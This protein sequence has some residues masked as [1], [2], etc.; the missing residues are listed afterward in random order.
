[1]VTTPPGARVSAGPAKRGTSPTELVVGAPLHGDVGVIA[2]LPGYESA[3]VT[4]KA[5][6]FSPTSESNLATL[7]LN[8]NPLP[9]PAAVPQAPPKPKP[10]APKPQPA[11]QATDEEPGST[12]AAAAP[13]VVPAPDEPVERQI[14]KPPEVAPE[15]P[16]EPAP[17]ERAPEKPSGKPE[18]VPANPFG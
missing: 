4:L 11:A 17:A 14:G 5:G 13:A 3:R 16:A 6:D 2:R 12:D 8:L 9:P 15:K 1:V 7:D 18:A 10:V